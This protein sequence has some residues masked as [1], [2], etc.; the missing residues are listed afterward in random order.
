MSLKALV[1]LFAEKFLQGKKEWVGSQ[2]IFSNA[3]PGTTFQVA[4]LTPQIYVPP[5]DGWLTLG[6]NDVAFNVGITGKMGMCCVNSQGYLRIT[7]PVRKG[8]AVSLYCETKYQQPLE[9]KFVPSEG[10]A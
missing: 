5:S 3:N 2:A 7:T 10:A 6:G 1:Q 4:H 9:A 8:D